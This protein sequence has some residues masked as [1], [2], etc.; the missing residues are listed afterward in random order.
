MATTPTTTRVTRSTVLGKRGHQTHA[1]S[2]SSS[3]P[4]TSEPSF[5]E[6]IDATCTSPESSP[7]AKR[8]RTSLTLPDG[9]E[10]IP[11]FLFD[12][13]ADSPRALRRTSTEFMTPTRPRATPRRQA[14]MSCIPNTPA[15]ALSRMSLQ[16]PPATPSTSLP[17]HTRARGLLRATCNSTADIAGRSAERNIILDFVTAFIGSRPSNDE[18]FRPVLYI[19]GSPGCGKTA[20]VNAILTSLEVQMLENEVNVAL[21]NCMA[22]N[23]LDAVWD[24]LLEELGGVKKRGSKVRNSDLVEELL[25]RRESKC[26]LV[27]DEIDHVAA[28]SQSLAALFALA[29]T[30]SSVLRIIG[31]ANTH[32]LTSSASKLSMHGVTGVQTL[33]FAPYESTQLL[34]ILQARLKPLSAL[35]SPTTEESVKKF[36]PVPTLTLLCKKTAAQT[37][38]VRALFEV[39]RGAI[40][41]VVAESFTSKEP[42]T[43]VSPAHILAALK[44]YAPASRIG[45]AAAA[46]GTSSKTSSNSEIVNKIRDL[47]LHARLVLLAL[48]LACKRVEAGLPVS[49]S[50][51]QM[52]TPPRSPVKRSSSSQNVVRAPVPPTGGASVDTTHLY[53]FY[54]TILSRGGSGVFTAV[55][56]SEFSDLAGVLETVGIVSLSSSGLSSASPVKGRKLAR[57][58]SFAGGMGKAGKS[59][60]VMFVEG[61]RADEVLRGLGIDSDGQQAPSKDAREEEAGAIWAREL[62]TINKESKLLAKRVGG[63]ATFDD[64]MED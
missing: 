39:L 32:T 36:L 48:L 42:P 51:S 38:D 1:E 35:D 8:A 6:F 34:E 22:L 27:L 23:G 43:S 62:S 12:A 18:E 55:S 46:P 15:T 25:A 59:Q 3:S 33:H 9:K 21:V 31:I 10:N 44:A 5:D 57:S 17:L 49:G 7:C 45:A 2:S 54:T 11:P 29:E 24:R 47:G 53:T 63:V 61:M 56:R 41:L 60:T 50:P 40:D 20:L 58:A 52:P 16:T 19:S 30:H 14:S 28:S 26:I 37:G 4:A 64:A 13:L